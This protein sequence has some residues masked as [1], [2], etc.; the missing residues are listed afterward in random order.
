MDIKKMITLYFVV[1]VIICVCIF[2]IYGVEEKNT[3][4][5]KRWI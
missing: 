4:T 1:A 3:Y 2:S 5:L